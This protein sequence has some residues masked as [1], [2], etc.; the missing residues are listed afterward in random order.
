[1][2]VGDREVLPQRHE[3]IVFSSDYADAVGARC[4][5]DET[6]AGRLG[7]QTLQQMDEVRGGKSFE[8]L[9]LGSITNCQDQGGFKDA[10][11][12]RRS[13]RYQQWQPNP[14]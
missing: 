2:V 8:R 1:M 9:A 10:P 7:Q 6:C 5:F 4:Q 11:G 12:C 13:R 3:E 14:D